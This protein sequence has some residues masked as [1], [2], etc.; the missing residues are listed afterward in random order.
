MNTFKITWRGTVLGLA[1]RTT[2]GTLRIPA[3]IEKEIS[4]TGGAA[5][6]ASLTMACQNLSMTHNATRAPFAEP[7]GVV[8][9]I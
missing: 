3:R 5:A 9:V 2:Q 7:N 8:E 4:K 6:V 1:F